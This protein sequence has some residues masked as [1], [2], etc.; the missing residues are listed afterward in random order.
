M[1]RIADAQLLRALD[2]ALDEALGDLAHHVDALDAG[3]ALAGV[4]KARPQGAG[5][6]VLDV[7]VG[8]HE[9]RVLAAE[10]EH[11]ALE[12]ARALLADTAPG[13]DRAGEEDLCDLG[14]H[15]RVSRSG[16][17]DGAHETLGHPGPLEDVHDL[18]AEQRRER[19]GLQD[20][21]VAGH[22]RE[23]DLAE[24]DRPGVVPGRDDADDAERLV[25]E[26]RAL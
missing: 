12:L 9:H 15:E 5:D 17:V 3:T 23:R 22:E 26:R 14:A 6:R 20:D 8:K 2:D 19:G 11:R 25:G 4:R 13:G 24:R 10:L 21:A 18:V 7:G 16:A 1:Q